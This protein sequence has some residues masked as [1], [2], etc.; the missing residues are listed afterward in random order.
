MNRSLL[1]TIRSLGLD[2]HAT[3]LCRID[4][5]VPLTPDG[6]VA[7]DTRLRRTLPTLQL[8]IDT[9]A[10]L[11]V[12]SHL[13]RPKGKP[14]PSL[15]MLPVAAWIA[16]ALGCEVVFAHE[17]CGD[18]V[19]QLVR[20]LPL[21]G[22]LVLENLRFDPREVAGDATM[23]R[24][25][26]KL[27]THFVLDAF[28]AMHRSHAS[29]TGIPPLLPTA[30]GLLV[31]KELRQLGSLLRMVKGPF[32]AIVG[33]A[34]VSDKLGILQALSE[35]VNHL[36][37]GG[38]MAYTFLA[39][40]GTPVGSSRVESNRL[41]LAAKLLADCVDRGV[42]VHLPTDHVVA[43]E[44]SADAAPSTV[45]EIPDG[46]MG[47][48]IGPA[49]AASWTQV[50]ST[51]RTVLWNGPVGVSEWE[52]FRAGTNQLAQALAESSAFTVVG[53]GDSVA[54]VQRLG[55]ADRIN[56]V[57]T[58]GGATLEYLQYGDLPGLQAL[59]KKL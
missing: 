38:A 44:F 20:D 35:R 9:G 8:I 42:G 13:G 28:G 43:T 59:R 50:L 47:L 32:G 41:E 31:S 54:A 45:T 11:V 24:D 55:L 36:F 23:A 56:H 2:A 39:A 19:E 15:S 12:C 5:N 49:T 18:D 1:P 33:G 46:Y 37:I 25:L 21:N 53:G 4:A 26:A 17:P 40:Q 16:D 7:D 10:K 58:G 14:N 6:Q 51:C 22:V 34:K 3:V 29:I 57:S 27:A 30:A 52:A 48:D